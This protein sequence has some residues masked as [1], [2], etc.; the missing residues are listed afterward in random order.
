MI[1]ME[2]LKEVMKIREIRP[3]VLCDRLGIKS[4]V[5]SERFKQKNVS[6]T[7]LNEMLRLMDYKIVVVPRDSRVPEGGFEIE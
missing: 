2:A 6:V 7:K 3:A 5:L 4:N 1:A